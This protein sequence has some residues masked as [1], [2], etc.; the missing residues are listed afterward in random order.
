MIRRS[1]R[2]ACSSADRRFPGPGSGKLCRATVCGTVPDYLSAGAPP[3]GRPT[4]AG[5][6]CTSQ[7]HAHVPG[8][9]AASLPR[10]YCRPR[11]SL[12]TSRAWDVGAARSSGADRCRLQRGTAAGPLLQP[13]ALL[14]APPEFTIDGRLHTCTLAH[15][16]YLIC[17]VFMHPNA[18]RTRHMCSL[19]MHRA[20]QHNCYVFRDR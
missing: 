16:S 8:R 2:R 17:A 15:C 9:P 5:Q 10:A 1:G 3:T 12:S 7:M 11:C 20:A 19:H 13:P 4:A 18:P 14:L 6:A